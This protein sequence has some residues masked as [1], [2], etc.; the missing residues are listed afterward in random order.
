M[1]TTESQCARSIPESRRVL[2]RN[3]SHIRTAG[4]DQETSFEAPLDSERTVVGLSVGSGDH[5]M[6]S[7]N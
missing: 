5:F 3:G 7:K 1:A 6:W 4:N 2:A